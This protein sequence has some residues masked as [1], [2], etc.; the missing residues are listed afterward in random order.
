VFEL[1][2]HVVS[3][4]IDGV[5]TWCVKFQ[6]VQSVNNVVPCEDSRI[7]RNREQKFVSCVEEVDQRRS[8][9]N[10]QGLRGTRTF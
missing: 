6:T 10:V 3:L 4:S 2:L 9:Q 1:N 8:V 7:R 5:F